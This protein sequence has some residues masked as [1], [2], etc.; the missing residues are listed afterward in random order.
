M[1]IRL[2]SKPIVSVD[3]CPLCGKE[4]KCKQSKSNDC[5][6]LCWCHAVDIP[7]SL[8]QQIPEEARGKACICRHCVEHYDESKE[9]TQDF[10]Y[11]SGQLV[12]TREYH[13]RRG[14]C[15]K[16]SCRHCPF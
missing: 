7:E 1:T 14:Y 16:N 6:D 9:T 3:Q 11:E 10:Y 2:N 15:C 13:L 12:F 8:L 5:P 4:N